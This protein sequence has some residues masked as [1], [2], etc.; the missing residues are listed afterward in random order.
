MQQQTFGDGE[1]LTGAVALTWSVVG[2]L[3]LIS[4]GIELAHRD[5]L[6]PQG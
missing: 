5:V 6:V 1:L 4:E 2:S 3:A